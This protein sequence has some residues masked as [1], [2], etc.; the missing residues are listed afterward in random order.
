MRLETSAGR[1]EVSHDDVFLEAAQAVDFAKGGGI[2]EHAGGVLEGRGGDEAVGLQGGFGDAQEDGLAFGGFTTLFA[3]VAI[4]LFEVQALDLVTPE[5]L[6]ITGIADFDFAEHLADD[7]FNVLVIDFHTLQTVNFLHFVDQVFLELVWPKD[8]Q[9]FMRHDRAFGELVALLHEVSVEHDDVLGTRDEV[10]F[11]F[12]GL[13]IA[14]D[15]LA[16]AAH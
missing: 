2:G 6:G 14:H 5:E 10:F 7:D 16:F 8:L 12:S 3:D 9:N 15:D 1:D 4:D 13:G 11:L